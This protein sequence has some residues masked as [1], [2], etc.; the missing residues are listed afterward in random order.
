MLIEISQISFR[1]WV[2]VGF[3]PE[4]E[5]IFQLLIKSRIEQIY[6]I[7]FKENYLSIELI[8]AIMALEDNN[9]LIWSKPCEKLINSINFY[10]FPLSNKTLY[11]FELFLVLNHLQHQHHLL[12]HQ[13]QQHHLTTDKI[14]MKSFK[15]LSL[16]S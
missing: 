4:T 8:A 1:N 12:H 13:F 3:D 7:Y 10:E 11:F 9:L 14:I 15:W 2:K 6:W 5:W 16:L